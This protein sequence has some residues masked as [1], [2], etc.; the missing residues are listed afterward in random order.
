MKK[1]LFLILKLCIYYLIG[2]ISFS[3]I[4]YITQTIVSAILF[5]TVINPIQDFNNISNIIRAFYSYYLSTYTVIYLLLVYMVNKYD[6][7]IVD[8]LNQKLT[9]VKGDDKDGKR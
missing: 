3:I 9:M 2:L 8:K 6:R 7:Y 4:A 5:E 1:R